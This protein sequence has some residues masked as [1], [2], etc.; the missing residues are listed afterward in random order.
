M[1]GYHLN[2]MDLVSSI[3]D[4]I[5]KQIPGLPAEPR[6]VNKVIEAV[7]SIC[8]EFSKPIVKSSEGMGLTAWLASDDVGM[9][10]KFMASVLSGKFEAEFA[11]PHDVS[12]LGRCIRMIRAVPELAER[13]F[14]LKDHHGRKWAAIAENWERWC[15]LYDEECESG[16]CPKLYAEMMA[17]YKESSK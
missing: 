15:A 12:D 3:M 13:I 17:A 8:D 1:S 16:R 9:S 6:L 7:N 11:Y 2:Q 5:S 14:L 10:S 4:A